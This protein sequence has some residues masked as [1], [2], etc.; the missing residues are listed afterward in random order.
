MLLER[1]L[2]KPEELE[3]ARARAAKH[4]K[5]LAEILVAEEKVKREDLDTFSDEHTVMTVHW[6]S[7][8]VAAAAAKASAPP[9]RPEEK[10]PP[11]VLE[12]AQKPE[13]CFDK[14]VL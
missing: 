2:I 3:L 4:Q 9:P 8:I 5:S 14:F 1:G 12:M 7:P 10:M 6:Q 13:Y 11:E